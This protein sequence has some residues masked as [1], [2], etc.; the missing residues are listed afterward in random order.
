MG[1]FGNNGGPTK[2]VVPQAG[3]PAILAGKGCPTLDQ[4]GN[5]RKNPDGCTIGSVEAP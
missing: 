4:R 1:P 5:A 2:T 3:S